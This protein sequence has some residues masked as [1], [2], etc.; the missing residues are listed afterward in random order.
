MKENTEEETLGE[1]NSKLKEG[2]VNKERKKF[3]N[4]MK[5]REKINEKKKKIENL[6]TLRKKLKNT[7][8]SSRGIIICG[9]YIF[10]EG[11]TN[12]TNIEERNRILRNLRNIPITQGKNAFLYWRSL[13]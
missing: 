5:E 12:V 6:L 8:I 9:I 3:V 13:Q 2:I 11:H 10:L 1:E 4:M 7:L